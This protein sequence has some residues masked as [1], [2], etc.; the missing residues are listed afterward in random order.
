MREYDIGYRQVS[1][2]LAEWVKALASRQNK[3]GSVGLNT[4]FLSG[5]RQ[6]NSLDKWREVDIPH[7]TWKPPASP[8]GNGSAWRG[9]DLPHGMHD[10]TEQV[11]KKLY[12]LM[13]VDETVWSAKVLFD[14]SKPSSLGMSRGSQKDWVES[15]TGGKLM[16][17][18][19][20]QSM[21]NLHIIQLTSL[22][23]EDDGNAPMRPRTIYLYT[24]TR[25]ILGFD[26]AKDTGAT[27]TITLENE[28]WN[29]NGTANIGLDFRKF[30]NISRLLM[31]VEGGDG[32]REK[33]RLDRVRLISKGGM[34][35]KAGQ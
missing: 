18:M 32:T 8:S 4:E 19:S 17:L 22:P 13:N 20:L 9:A 2:V 1:G 14:V 21:V 23:P 12:D 27:Q 15:R 33:T 6:P 7:V 35:E 28:D 34:L 29:S 3:S 25:H 26:Q 31:F 16:L 10:I 5:N 11:D 30:Q 24:N